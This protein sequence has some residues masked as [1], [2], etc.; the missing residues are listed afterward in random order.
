MIKVSIC[1]PSYNN[2]SGMRRLLDSIASQNYRDFEVIVSDNSDNNFTKE[3]TDNYSRSLPLHYYHTSKGNSTVNWNTS[4]SYANGQY[5]KIMHHDDWFTTSDSLLLMVQMLDINPF[6]NLAF[7]GT[8]QVNLTDMSFYDRYISD[9]D[10]QSINL[11]WHNLF[12]DN[13][14]GAPSSVIVRSNLHLPNYDSNLKW[15]VDMDYYM[16]ILSISPKMVYSQKPLISIGLDQQQLTNTCTSNKSLI[17]NEYQ[18]VYKKYNLNAYRPI[19]HIPQDIN[20]SNRFASLPLS[21]PIPIYIRKMLSIIYQYGTFND[22]KKSN[23]SI[24][25]Y[26]LGKIELKFFRKLQ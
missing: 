24:L 13:V 5:I 16:S 20:R 3:I 17:M 2:P 19:H 12:I 6:C 22:C 7:C 26:F 18:Y 10:Y 1:I 4:I 15:L 8:R 23:I 9:N 21:S 11:D 14:I 25:L